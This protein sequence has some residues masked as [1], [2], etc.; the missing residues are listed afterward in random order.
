MSIY[1][2][3]SW[4]FG[5]SA[6]KSNGQDGVSPPVNGADV[7]WCYFMGDIEGAYETV[8]DAD[9]VMVPGVPII[10]LG[11]LGWNGATAS[12][13]R[14]LLRDLQR[15][16]YFLRGNW[17]ERTN[18]RRDGRRPGLNPRQV[19]PGLWAL[20]DGL[21]M[22]IG[23]W[24][25]GVLGGAAHAHPQ[26]RHACPPGGPPEYISE[27]AQQ[28]AQAWGPLDI[29][30]SH[31][32]P[33]SVIPALVTPAQQHSL[34]L[35]ADW[36]DPAALLVESAWRSSGSPVLLCGHMHKPAWHPSGVRVVAHEGWLAGPLR[37]ELTLDAW[38]SRL[39]QVVQGRLHES[40][41]PLGAKSN[42]RSM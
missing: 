18:P 39:E 19:V 37:G 7:P 9:R 41:R 38:R 1:P 16:I 20:P 32:P 2:I 40:Q 26:F 22:Q 23:P 17:D 12:S 13:W 31:T 5:A 3:P 11:D 21:S 35:P 6:P 33:H 4:S 28:E 42:Q 25:V 30:L 29:M 24:R 10:Q 14:R 15:P 34:H 36:C 27:E 8:R